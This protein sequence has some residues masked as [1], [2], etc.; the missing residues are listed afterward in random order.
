MVCLTFKNPCDSQDIQET[1]LSQQAYKE[2]GSNY[3]AELPR[4]MNAKW[5]IPRPKNLEKFAPYLLYPGKEAISKTLEATTQLGK[6]QNKV[7]LG[8]HLKARNPIF[9]K[10]RLM[11]KLAT[12]TWY[13]TCPSFEGY[14]C[15]QIFVGINSYDIF[16]YGMKTELSGPEALLDCF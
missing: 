7:P 4:M 8:P 2:F 14:N 1:D 3:E 12:D 13:A 10:R 16:L 15:C 6:L 11:E 9:S 5:T